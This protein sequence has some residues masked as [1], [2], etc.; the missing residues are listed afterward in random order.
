M[1]LDDLLQLFPSKLDSL[2]VSYTYGSAQY[3]SFLK[4]FQSVPTIEVANLLIG[5]RLIPGSLVETNN[6][7]LTA[8]IRNIT[9]T[10]AVFSGVSFECLTACR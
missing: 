9:D 5:G 2:G 4:G 3:P 1:E 6:E 7:A 8:A 10:G